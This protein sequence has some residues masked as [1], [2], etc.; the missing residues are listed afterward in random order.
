MTRSELLLL[1]VFAP[2]HG[3]GRPGDWLTVSC[4]RCGASVR[5]GEQQKHIDW[6][7]KIE[8]KEQQ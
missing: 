2:R 5:E 4:P 1:L 8:L 3:E 7:L 6:H